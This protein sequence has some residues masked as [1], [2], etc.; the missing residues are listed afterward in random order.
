MSVYA[1]ETWPTA[2]VAVIVAV[3]V[4]AATGTPKTEPSKL[5]NCSPVGKFE[6]E[7]VIGF[8]A[9]F[10]PETRAGPE[11]KVAPFTVRTGDATA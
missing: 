11:L 4:P 7:N 5:D 10:E 1:N 8:A 9:V 3:V 2:L 6:A